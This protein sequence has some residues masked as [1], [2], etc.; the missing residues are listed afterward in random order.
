MSMQIESVPV[1]DLKEYEKNSR[2]HSDDLVAKIAASVEEFGFTNPILI[3]ESNGVIAGH[4]RLQAAKRI[5][6]GEVPC[7]RLAHLSESQKRAY[8]IADN[9]I[10]ESG[11]WDDEM[12]KMEIMELA[13][14][15]YDLKLT[16][17]DEAGLDSILAIS[18]EV[19]EAVE[20]KRD[21]KETGHS[22]QDTVRQVILIYTSDEYPRVM[23]AM[24]EYAE[25]HGLSSNTEVVNH[26]LENAPSKDRKK[27][28]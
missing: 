5:N 27:E 14:D 28:D 8:V 24:R 21:H 20:K 26:L 23:E 25:E 4:G 19:M 17:F 3:D 9:K 16:G 1:S 15:D 12:L 18:E 22:Q 6:M 10:A 13:Q 7:I 11:G 2:T